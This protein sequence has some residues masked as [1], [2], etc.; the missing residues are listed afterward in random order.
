[1][2]IKWTDAYILEKRGY[3]ITEKRCSRCKNILKLGSKYCPCC[4]RKFKETKI[5]N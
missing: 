2:N 3:Y 1:M 5:I 4:G